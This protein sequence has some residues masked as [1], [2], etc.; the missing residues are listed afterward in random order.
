MLIYHQLMV[1]KNI[2]QLMDDA[3]WDKESKERYYISENKLQK[4]CCFCSCCFYELVVMLVA[5]KSHR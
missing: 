4:S 3:I 1:I 5:V 2:L